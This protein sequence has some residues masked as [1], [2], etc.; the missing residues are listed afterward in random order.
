MMPM[1]PFQQAMANCMN[2][3]VDRIGQRAPRYD[4]APKSRNIHEEMER[5]FSDLRDGKAEIPEAMAEAMCFA[6]MQAVANYIGEHESMKATLYET[7]G[8]E[9]E[10][11]EHH[12]KHKKFKEFMEQMKDE[13]LLNRKKDL[14]NKHFDDLSED[15]TKVILELATDN[16]KRFHASQVHMDVSAFER[17]K[18]EAE[19]KIKL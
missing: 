3:I 11:P 14:I 18:H 16:S 12:A 5:Y 9:S 2:Q 10:M 4:R 13:P 19:K 15:E 8:G 17:V 1:N 7:R 6:A